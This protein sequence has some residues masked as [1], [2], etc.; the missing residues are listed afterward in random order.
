MRGPGTAN[1]DRS[2]TS[3]G[4]RT[5][6]TVLLCCGLA[7]GCGSSGGSRA[8][9]TVPVAQR[10]CGQAREAAAPLVQG[11]LSLRII[12]HDPANV[13]CRLLGH[14]LRIEVVAQASTQAWTEWDTT[15]THQ[16][17][18]YDSG[19][20]HQPAQIPNNVPVPGAPLAAWIAAQSELFATN[21]SQTQGG[22]YV[23][24]TVKPGPASGSARLELAKAITRATVAVAPRGPSSPPPD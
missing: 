12:D 16:V 15:Q 13:E 2:R 19:G 7:G 22:T 24:V 11:E 5:T 23:T 1:A 10:V 6:L 18:V 14:R 9:S 20:F 4:R 8:H 17:Q 21:G 3:F